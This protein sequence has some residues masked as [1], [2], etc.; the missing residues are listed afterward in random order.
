MLDGANL[1]EAD[2]DFANLDGVTLKGAKVKKTIFPQGRLGH[3]VIVAAV[4]SGERL[5]MDSVQGV[6]D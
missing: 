4:R 3:Q 6:D 5:R 1:E 2:F